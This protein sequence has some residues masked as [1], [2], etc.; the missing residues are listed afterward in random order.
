M[1]T[2]ARPFLA[3]YPGVCA[4]TGN[5]Y[6]AGA[7]IQRGANGWETANAAEV[8]RQRQEG[9]NLSQTSGLAREQAMYEAAEREHRADRDRRNAYR[10]NC[11][12]CDTPLER[13]TVCDRCARVC[14]ERDDCDGPDFYDYDD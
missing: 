11:S 9:A 1:K 14:G 6:P 8:V 4:T 2:Q 7:L 13:G 10:A 3:R 5:R 12:Y